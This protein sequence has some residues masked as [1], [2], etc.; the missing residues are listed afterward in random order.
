LYQV[1]GKSNVHFS[2]KHFKNLNRKEEAFSFEHYFPFV[3][4]NSNGKNTKIIIDFCDPPDI[5]E[6]GYNW[7]N[8]YGKINFN[9]S[10]T[11]DKYTPQN[12]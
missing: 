6:L 3:V 4:C 8:I 2:A 11:E 1:Y 12:K 10:Q 7:C 5:S 9:P